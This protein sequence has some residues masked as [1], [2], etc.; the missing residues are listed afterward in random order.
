MPCPG[1]CNAGQMSTKAVVQAIQPKP[2]DLGFVRSLGLPLQ[3]A[4]IVKKAQGNLVRHAAANDCNVGCASKALQAVGITP[5]VELLVTETSCVD[6]NDDLIDENGLGTLVD[7]VVTVVDR[8]SP[9]AERTWR[10]STTPTRA[11]SWPD[12]GDD[13]ERPRRGATDAAG[14]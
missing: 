5:D 1:A 4:G 12:R 14:R 9:T 3:I 2:G 10:R 7:Q 11:P 8:L 6:Q 13:V